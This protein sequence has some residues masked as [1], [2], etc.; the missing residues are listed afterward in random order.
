M[1]RLRLHA[2]KRAES[3]AAVDAN[4]GSDSEAS[5]SPQP[6]QLSDGSEY[7]SVVEIKGKSSFDSYN[8][9]P[10]RELSELKST[11]NELQTAYR[12]LEMAR[13][14][15]LYE[16][17]SALQLHQIPDLETRL[18]EELDRAYEGP[19]ESVEGPGPRSPSHT[20]S[21][22]D[23]S[24][25][26]EQQRYHR[27]DERHHRKQRTK[28]AR[29][30]DLVEST[31]RG[32]LSD[33]ANLDAVE[34]RRGSGSTDDSD[35]QSGSPVVAPIYNHV[36]R[37]EAIYTGKE[38]PRRRTQEYH[39]QYIPPKKS[40]NAALERAMGESTIGHSGSQKYF[41]GSVRLKAL[42]PA[43]HRAKNETDRV[44]Q[45]VQK[46]VRKG[47]KRVP[48]FTWPLEF[49]IKTGTA[50]Q[51]AAVT[52]NSADQGPEQEFL[53]AAT[54]DESLAIDS[55]RKRLLMSII[56]EDIDTRCR[57]TSSRYQRDL[58]NKVLYK[59]AEVGSLKRVESLLNSFDGTG[60]RSSLD[61]SLKR[62]LVLLTKRLLVF[63][64]PL[65]MEAE[66][67]GKYWGAVQR[68]VSSSRGVRLLSKH[69][70]FSD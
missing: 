14:N 63:F 10:S 2:V 64:V 60:Q 58:G 35:S 53:K 13:Q 59:K 69:R 8:S 33:I 52:Q 26:E 66:I 28:I 3:R 54:T 47:H 31:V 32:G 38:R 56:L 4:A 16:D 39:M 37:G 34:L 23:A 22:D 20:L 41:K 9:T 18:I 36:I 25:L 45:R 27:H 30:N 11:E 51:A 46:F 55:V 1:I 68:I 70:V 61:T 21:R 48:F 29:N 7:S 12:K 42:Q 15:D 50:K 67:I 17:V 62:T 57:P 19:I 40:I 43:A 49:T 5:S 24:D 6:V 44:R 65:E